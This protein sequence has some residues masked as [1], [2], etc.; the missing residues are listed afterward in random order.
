MSEETLLMLFVAL[1]AVAAISMAVAAAAVAWAVI[2]LLG[3][4]RLFVAQLRRLGRSGEAALRH[5]GER[6]K[7]AADALLP[8][9][10]H[11]GKS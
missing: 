7:S 9:D 10:T 8:N 11:H 6:L 1:V 2:K 5:T 3:E 4:A